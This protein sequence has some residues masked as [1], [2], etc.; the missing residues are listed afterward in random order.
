MSILISVTDAKVIFDR[1]IRLS[2][3][4]H[5]RESQEEAKEEDN[6][7]VEQEEY[8]QQI[9]PKTPIQRVQ[10]NHPPEQIIGNKDE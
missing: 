1:G 3:V 6:L 5:P 8:E 10:K 7:E 9:P 4:G 2:Q